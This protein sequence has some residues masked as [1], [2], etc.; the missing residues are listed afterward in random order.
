MRLVAAVLWCSLTAAIRF[1]NDDDATEGK[2]HSQQAPAWL[3]PALRE[4]T[5]IATTMA[6]PPWCEQWSCDANEHNAE[7]CIHGRQPEPCRVCGCPKWCDV[8]S[9]NNQ[10]WCRDG[11]RPPICTQCKVSSMA[12]FSRGPVLGAG[13]KA[14]WVPDH[15]NIAVSN[16]G[17]RMQGDSRA[18]LIEDHTQTKW[19][20][21][22][23]VRFDLQSGFR[24]DIDLSNVPCGCLACVYLVVMPDPSPGSPNY[25]DMGDNLGMGYHGGTCTE[26]DILEANRHAMQITIHTEKEGSFGSGKC[27]R[28][29]CFVKVGPKG[30]DVLRYE[31]GESIRGDRKKIDSSKPF[32]VTAQVDPSGALTVVL[33]Q[34][35][36]QAIVYDRH[37]AGNPQGHGVPVNALEGTK[38][39]M[40]K[41]ALV[42]SLWSASDNS[43]LDGSCNEC[44]ENEAS[45]LLMN[46][47]T[48]LAEPPPPRPPL[49]PSPP[50]SPCPPPSLPPNPPSPSPRPPWPTW[51]E[52]RPPPPQPPPPPPFHSELYGVT[53]DGERCTPTP[54]REEQQEQ[55]PVFVLNSGSNAEDTEG[56]NIMGRSGDMTAGATDF[57]GDRDVPS[58][59]TSVLTG[60]GFGLVAM[61][62]VLA[63]NTMRSSGQGSDDA[64]PSKASFVAIPKADDDD[65]LDGG[66][67]SPCERDIRNGPR[68]EEED[69]DEDYEQQQVADTRVEV[70]GANLFKPHQAKQQAIPKPRGSK[71]AAMFLEEKPVSFGARRDPPP[72]A[73]LSRTSRPTLQ[74]AAGGFD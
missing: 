25:C 6:C 65:A 43:W 16:G 59:I 19:E 70:Q 24:F 69:D 21:H 3:P 73:E 36:R 57:G 44:N 2:D 18:Y 7:W 34:D 4:H 49:P 51:P 11:S 28:N 71:H 53:C 17:L 9:C 8:W 66:R 61:L 31:Y 62:L 60:G 27:D 20:K 68:E 30:P 58:S 33:S 72:T 23:Y 13:P 29:G 40:G 55:Q 67:V 35:G 46:L 47:R 41:L 52:P 39:A 56:G 15:G 32:R 64:S 50:P 48:S 26:I 12:S 5:S 45:F 1:S 74:L 37:M 14:G 22:K 10:A 42:T 38:A 54:D 63:L